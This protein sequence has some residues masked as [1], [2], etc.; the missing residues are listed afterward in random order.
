MSYYRNYNEYLGSQRCCNLKGPGPMGPVGPT[1]PA[2]VGPPGIGYTG[3]TGYT[4][5][6]GKNCKGDTGPTGPPGATSGLTGP[7][8]ATG[9]RGATGGTPWVETYYQGTTGPGYTGIGY[10]GDV[11]VFG[12]LYVQGG[13]DP[14]YLALEPQAIGPTGFVNPLWVDSSGNLR[15]DKILLGN[16]TDTLTLDET[17]ITHSSP[18]AVSPLDISSNSSINMTAD[19]IINLTSNNNE[20]NLNSAALM[21]LYGNTLDITSTGSYI[22]L[23]SADYISLGAVGDINLT[24]N[25]GDINLTADTTGSGF[26]NMN[27]FG[28]VVI[29]QIGVLTPPDYSKTTINGYTIETF[30]DTTIFDGT[31]NQMIVNPVELFIDN[32]NNT[33]QTQ[34]YGRYAPNAIEIYDHTNSGTNSSR[35]QI[36]SETFNYSVGGVVKPSFYQFQL[37]SNNIFRYSLT[38]IQMGTSGTGVNINLNNIEYP[39]TFNNASASLS[40]T[41]NAVQ[42]FNG[43]SL[44]AT[45]FNASATNVGT[46]FTITNTNAT[47]LSVTTTGGTQLI[48]SSTG[49]PSAVSRVLAQGNSHIFTAIQTTSGST[50]GWSMV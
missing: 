21:T 4:G 2:S 24:S 37:A 47:N 28:G 7:T 23:T 38:G 18:L 43:T 10:T 27:A 20:I 8:G 31:I 9:A 45:L 19:E 5:P 44:T 12:A 15:S 32:T 22:G 41:S 48:Y 36:N 3:Y 11:M 1:G 39:T 40:T 26:I 14:T 46:Q 17:S 34:Q 16:G 50:Y 25:N 35:I 29:N 30:Q 13:I 42:T 33:L 6:T 49:A